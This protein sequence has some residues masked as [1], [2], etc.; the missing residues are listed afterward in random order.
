[1]RRLIEPIFLRAKETW[2][3]TGVFSDASVDERIAY[4]ERIDEQEQQL[5]NHMIEEARE[6]RGRLAKRYAGVVFDTDQHEVVSEISETRNATD[7]IEGMRTQG[8]EPIQVRYRVESAMLW[9]IAQGM[10]KIQLDDSEDDVAAD[11]TAMVKM[12]LENLF[13]RS[14]Q[15]DIWTYHDP[16]ESYRVA[17]FALGTP[18]TADGLQAKR[19]NPICRVSNDG[20]R[21][22]FHHR[23]KK[24][25]RV[26]MKLMKWY[27]DD[28][29]HP[30]RL[31]DRCGLSL[32]AKNC[33]Q[34]QALREQFA[35]LIV[36]RGGRF[37]V[38]H[39]NLQDGHR[40]DNQNPHSSKHFRACKCLFEW[41]GRT[42]ELMLMTFADHYNAKY[43]LGSENHHLYRTY[44]MREVYLK[45]LYPESVY[46]IS[47]DSSEVANLMK[48]TV[49]EG[50]TQ[51]LM[52]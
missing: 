19:H 28:F 12:V 25:F 13:K 39:D 48:Q 1:M 29:Q 45:F 6:S 26:L 14:E 15:L 31:T 4:W 30:F 5:F 10:T 34:V 50:L 23:R 2:T 43:A 52:R 36:E 33:D 9:D 27:F 22:L 3:Q 32:V 49:M 40:M 8:S 21:V 44:Q 35:N 7:L 18:G 51:E 20:F 37:W 42:F 47:W 24:L 46:G 41:G 17:K 38:E 11:M 16:D